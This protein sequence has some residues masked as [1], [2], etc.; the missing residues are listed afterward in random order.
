MTQEYILEQRRNK[1]ELNLF[2]Y[3]KGL[4]NDLPEHYK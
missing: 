3:K 1:K 2:L 4:I